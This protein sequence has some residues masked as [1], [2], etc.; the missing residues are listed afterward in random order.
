VY[1]LLIVVCLFVLFHLT[2]VFSVLLRF[3]D[4]NYPFSIFKLFLKQVKTFTF[5]HFLKFYS[6]K[7]IFKTESKNT[8]SITYYIIILYIE[9]EWIKQRF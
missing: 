4:S 3:T 5:D 8:F 9:I 2:I 1:V 7:E 6:I